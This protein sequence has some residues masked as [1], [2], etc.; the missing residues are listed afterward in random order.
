ME[1]NLND[2][3]NDSE[4]YSPLTNTS[5][6]NIPTYLPQNVL[7]EINNN[8]KY[9]TIFSVED[10]VKIINKA[11]YFPFRMIHRQMKH[12]S[13]M[14][15]MIIDFIGHLAPMK[16]TIYNNNK[17]DYYIDLS[18]GKK[19]RCNSY[20]QCINIDNLNNIQ[21]IP[22]KESDTN[23]IIYI[24]IEGT[25]IGAFMND[26]SFVNS[27][28]EKERGFLVRLFD[29]FDEL[30]PLGNSLNKHQYFSGLNLANYMSKPTDKVKTNKI[31]WNNT[32]KVQLIPSWRNSASHGGS[33]RRKIK[34]NIYKVKSHK[35]SR[36]TIYNR[37]RK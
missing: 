34:K 16:Y 36:K 23:L 31:T 10:L 18:S 35:K 32:V 37:S 33:T 27:L 14:S 1:I 7:M 8:S 9:N 21:F 24:E 26:P 17:V 28:T 2:M 15:Q 22:F 4:L 19:L 11:I 30:N 3:N 25:L 5:Q 20:K 12:N 13:N 6:Y 29:N